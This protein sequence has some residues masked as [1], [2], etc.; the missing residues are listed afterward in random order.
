MSKGST[1]PMR[2]EIRVEETQHDV[3]G[4]HR[5]SIQLH[6]LNLDQTTEQIE[7]QIFGHEVFSNL[8]RLC[9]I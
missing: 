3:N 1:G 9:L 8:A 4:G 5:D 7:A 6:N 2:L